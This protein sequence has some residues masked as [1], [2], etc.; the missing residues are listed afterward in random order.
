MRRGFWSLSR[1]GCFLPNLEEAEA[2]AGSA[3]PQTAITMLGKS[4]PTVALKGGP[5]GAWVTSG[6]GILHG[7]ARPCRSSIPRAPAMPSMPASCMP[8]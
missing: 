1:R 3:D 7:S 2:I 4:F 8:G 5:S 6:D